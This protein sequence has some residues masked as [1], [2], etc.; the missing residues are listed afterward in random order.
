MKRSIY[1]SIILLSACAPHRKNPLSGSFHDMTAHYN[2]YFIAKERIKEIEEI[3][4]DA[5]EWNYDKVLPIF[6]QFD[7]TQSAGLKTQVE[8]CIQKSSISIQRHPG[9]KWEDDSYILVGKARYYSMEFADA[10]NTLKYV[11]NKGE[12]DESKHEALAELIRVYTDFGEFNNAVAVVDYLEKEELSSRNKKIYHLNAA[13]L[14]Q[15]KEDENKMVGHLVRAEEQ[16]ASN[17]D[18][19]RI[20]FIIGQ[21]YHSLGF[22]GEAFRYYK[23]TLKNNPKYELEFYTKLY[24]AQVTELAKNNDLKKIQKYFKTLLRDPKNEEYKDKIYYELAGFEFDNA[25][26]DEAISNYRLSIEASK[27]NQR[28]KG[29]SYLRLGEIYYDSLKNY[30]LAKSY[31]DSTVNTL[32]KEEDDYDAIKIRQEIL[33]DFVEQITVI[34]KND[35]LIHLST[36]PEDSVLA[37]AVSMLEAEQEK[38]KKRKEDREKVKRQNTFE[39]EASLIQTSTA[40]SVWYFSN[41]NALS[42]G[43]SEFINKWGDRPLEDNWR[44]KNKTSN[45][46][47]AE[48]AT[49]D[50][51]VESVSATAEEIPMEVKAQSLISSIPKS[52]E[53]KI[54]LLV[55][56][57]EAYYQ[58]GNIYN[59][60]LEEDQNAAESFET[61]LSR[62]PES[63]YEPEVLYQLFLI[64]KTLDSEKSMM[65]GE[66]LKT[67]FPET[68]YAKL[69]ENPNY[70]EESF[71]TSER[72]KKLYK[73]LYSLYQAGEFGTVIHQSDSALS[74]DPENEFSDNIKLLQ[75]LAIGRKDG[76]RK[77]QYEIGNFPKEYPE[78]ELV[79]YA[80]SLLIA[81]EEFQQNRYNSARARFIESFN[82]KHFFVLVYEIKQSLNSTVPAMVDKFLKDN[83]FSTLKT[84][85]LI[86]DQKK[87]MLLVNDFPGKGSAEGFSKMFKENI[88]L[89]DT[90]KGE[91]IELFVITEDNFDIFYKTKDVSAYLNF[92]EK[93]YQ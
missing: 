80:N 6:A 40:N 4:F 82:Q 31:Y 74:V 66:A 22:E 76:N 44:R 14:Y 25:N 21:T 72:L 65:R 38:E 84:G 54:K 79:P 13:Y 55:E 12:N 27:G 24:M 45:V 34:Q 69:V 56:V 46:L 18:K 91:K 33:V 35:S 51:P 43:Q 92:F 83:N 59:L 15:R 75:I 10:V 30:S 93:H 26:L 19:A 3:I 63:E 87:S 32:P 39:S 9:S 68:I 37:L 62:F 89:S 1:I 86:L 64:Y 5:Q 78:S 88:S 48:T 77:Y 11:N 28:Q 42:K 53:Q 70:K 50:N 16:F 8:D 57:E 2:S 81:S 23:N 29:Y 58:L 49:A 17:S 90:F 47:A 85:N 36:L 67:K 73:S 60:R 7:S 52:E 41:T 61:L 20:N 71:A